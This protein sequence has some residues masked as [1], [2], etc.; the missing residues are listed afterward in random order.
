MMWKYPDVQKESGL[1]VIQWLQKRQDIVETNT[2][3]GDTELRLLAIGIQRDIVVVTASTDQSCTF[4]QKF[5]C[6][7]PPLP[8]MR[9]GTFVPM[10][11]NKLCSQWNIMKPP[12]F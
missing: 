11:T 5:V 10:T 4:A 3:G 8:K 1:I 2:W 7:P 6:Q 9:G 12:P